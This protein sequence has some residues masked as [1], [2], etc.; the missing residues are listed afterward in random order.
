MSDKRVYREV[1]DLLNKL[2]GSMNWH[3]GGPGGGV[4]HLELHGRRCDVECRSNAV[5]FLDELYLPS[6]SNPQTQDDYAKPYRL[7]SDAFWRLVQFP[8]Q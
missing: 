4:W 5:N 2:G 3:A 8:W 7:Q 6:K 1:R